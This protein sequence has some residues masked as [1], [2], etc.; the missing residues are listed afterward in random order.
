MNLKKV[1]YVLHFLSEFAIRQRPNSYHR[2]QLKFVLHL[3]RRFIEACR[4]NWTTRLRFGHPCGEGLVRCAVFSS[5]KWPIT[6]IEQIILALRWRFTVGKHSVKIKKKIRSIT[7]Y[8]W[9]ARCLFLRV[10]YPLTTKTSRWR[11]DQCCLILRSL[12]LWKIPGGIS[13]ETSVH[14]VQVFH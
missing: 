8:S 7:R 1:E 11:F 4:S 2:T 10:V 14:G 9:Y 12:V 3:N 5:I 13:I 6:Y